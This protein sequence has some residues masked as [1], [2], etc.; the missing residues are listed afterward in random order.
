MITYSPFRRHDDCEIYTLEEFTDLI[1]S[2]LTD[3]DGIG[4]QACEHGLSGQQIKISDLPEIEID[5]TCTHIA[6]YQ[7][8]WRT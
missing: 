1:K 5:E 3:D 4:V 2:G 8:F 6:W 7:H